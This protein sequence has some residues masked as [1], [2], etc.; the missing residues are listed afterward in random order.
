MA[1][2]LIHGGRRLSGTV[3]V[4]GNK[5]AALPLLAA[6]LLTTEECVLATCRG[7]ATSRSCA[8]SSGPRRRGGGHRHV[9]AARPLPRDHTTEPDPRSWAGCAG[10][11][12]CSP[13]CSAARGRAVL[14]EPGG[15]FPAAARSPRTCARSP[16][17]GPLSR[18]APATPRGPGR[19]ARRLDLPRRGLGDRHRD[20]AARRRPGGTTEIRNAAC[21]PHVAELCRFLRDGRR[22]GGR[23]A[24]RTLRVTGRR[25][26]GGAVHRSRRLHRGG[27][28]GRRGR[29]DR[30][31]ASRSGG[32]APDIE[33]IAAVLSR[34]RRA[35]RARGRPLRGA[36]SSLVG[37]G[38]VTTGA[39]AR[40]PERHRQPRHRA[41]HAG[42]GQHARPRLAVRAAAL[43]PRAAE[44]H[45]ADLFLCD[46][47]RIIVTGRRRLRGRRS[48]AATSARAWRLSWRR[49][50]RTVRGPGW[51]APRAGRG[52]RS[53]E[54]LKPR[55]DRRMPPLNA[56]RRRLAES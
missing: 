36:P 47:H 38:R 48:T 45:G 35:L 51:P 11:C 6:C 33:P 17:W 12:C 28:L 55:R 1:E 32:R 31:R 42:R 15:D 24:R 29:R 21:E 5:N 26:L 2:L 4:E 46:P 14:G 37:A 3:A 44:R 53:H 8:G 7:S 18:D 10:R 9:D 50:R 16:R 19:P 22:R 41:R 20:G 39:L 25:R 30:G 43:R 40:L 27:Q 13:R 56:G 34:D 23:S 54:R 52:R 49:S